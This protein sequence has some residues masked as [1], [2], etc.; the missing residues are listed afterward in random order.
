MKEQELVIKIKGET[1]KAT[2]EII[3][4][5]K[6]IGRLG[7]QTAK[8]KRDSAGFA[9]S[10]SGIAKVTAS[11]ISLGVAMRGISSA[12][13]TIADFEVQIDKLGAITQATDKDMAALEERA[14]SLGETTRYSASQ[15]AE[16]MNF[17]AMAGFD[18]NQILEATPGVLNLATVGMTDLGTAADIASNV[19]SG[20]GLDAKETNRIVD[21]F[22]KTI[23]SS[24]TNVEELGSAMSKVAPVAK[25]YGMSVEETAAALGVMADAGIKAE[26]AG[27][28]LK[29]ALTK[30][31]TDS[32]AKKALDNLGTSAYDAEGNF[33]GLIQIIKEIKP[34]LASMTEE[35]K[36]AALVDLFGKQALAAGNVYIAQLDQIESKYKANTKASGTA[37]KMAV[38]MADNLAGAYAEFNA[39]LESVALKMS[40]ELIPVLSEALDST[41]DWMRSLDEDEISKFV[42]TIGTLIEAI[43]SV[44]TIGSNLNDVLAPDA[45]FGEGVG[46]LDLF[47][48]GLEAVSW[49][50]NRIT[51]RI[52]DTNASFAK[53]EEAKNTVA[54]LET[55]VSSFTGGS[56]SEF[57][58]LEGAILDTI[59][60]NAEQADQWA[61]KDPELYAD[62]IRAIYEE[63]NKLYDIYGKLKEQ[64]PFDQDAESARVVAEATANLNSVLEQHGE[65]RV[66]TSVEA[67][68]K[69]LEVEKKLVDGI[70]QLNEELAVKLEAI[71]NQ[72]Y[73]SHL[74]TDGKIREIGYNLLSETE[75]YNQKQLDAEEALA[76]AKEAIRKGQLEKAKAHMAVYEKLVTD[77]A[78]KEITDNKKVTKTKEETAQAA[79][80][81]LKKVK[82]LED[83]FFNEKKKLLEEEKKKVIEVKQVELA[84]IQKNKEAISKETTSKHTIKDNGKEVQG[85]IDKLK[86]N[87]SST[88]TVNIKYNYP[89][90]GP[91]AGTSAGSVPNVSDSM[92]ASAVASLGLANAPVK[93]AG[94]SP[95]QMSND[96][97]ALGTLTLSVGGKEFPALVP[98]E[99]ADALQMYIN[100]EG[101][102]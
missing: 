18:T 97:G 90:G 61:N 52:A 42:G 17:L 58:A 44:I 98:K 2:K 56:I 33:K 64:K 27:T 22:A 23:T 55:A 60:A 47:V 7:K 21:V 74:S 43:Q 37:E 40:D 95:A 19:I 5:N 68:T 3:K 102:L 65:T 14:K 35:A 99:V 85:K 82:K 63:N 78:G 86:K 87:T 20:F 9:N 80:E 69:I 59:D 4:L 89:A 24:N 70:A 16:S 10:F 76:K 84:E 94:A 48:T 81:G 39:A 28:Q 57:K 71:E 25:A 88:H 50:F 46:V 8:A 77:S 11:F 53:L 67:T 45:W 6:E 38:K 31:A 72:R 79:V 62:K 73:L 92:P 30:L 12:V 93:T 36:N 96:L 101:G 41:S 29:I 15:V 100:T 66:Q 32:K 49:A 1:S 91:P 54:G 51:L 83:A 34:G 75:K 26:L 13:T